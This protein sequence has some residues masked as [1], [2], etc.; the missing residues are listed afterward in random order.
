MWWELQIPSRRWNSTPLW[1]RSGTE[2]IHLDTESTKSRRKS[3]RF[4]WWIER[5]STNNAF[6]RLISGCR[7]STRWF[8]VYLRRLHKPPSRWT[9]SQTLHGKRRII[10]YSTEIY[11]RH[12]SR[13]YYLGCI[14]AEPYRWLW[15]HR[16]IKRSVRCMDRFHTIFLVKG[17]ASRRI[18]VVREETNKTASNIQTWSFVARNLEKYVKEF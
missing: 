8:L 3:R 15:E 16:W 17:K 14:A 4:F 18:H 5:V 11:W 6:S 10:S 13:S 2:N 9:K 12:W 1:R 7:W